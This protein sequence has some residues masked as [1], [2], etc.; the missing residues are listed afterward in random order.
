GRSGA[1]VNGYHLVPV[2]GRDTQM[3]YDKSAIPHG[4]YW[5]YD[6]SMPQRQLNIDGSK[7]FNLAN[8]NHELKFGFGYRRTPITSASATPGDK[9][10]IDYSYSSKTPGF[11][12]T[13]DAAP[14]YGSNYHNLYVGDTVTAGNLTL[15]AG[16]RYDIQ[17]AKN[18]ASAVAAN[19]AYPD[20]LPAVSF[21]GDTR[22]LE[23]KS[24]TPRL[25]A[26]YALGNSKRTLLRGSYAKYAD[27]ISAGAV[28]SN[29]PF[30]A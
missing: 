18:N 11:V 15:N 9:T 20:L 25:A 6:Q 21:P 5:S 19:T 17:R 13:R 3:Y 7:F 14:N 29:N 28:G 12:V 16:F 4:S 30:Y 22:S 1:I 24:I 26:T 23:W 10:Y 8:L 2:G 27:Q